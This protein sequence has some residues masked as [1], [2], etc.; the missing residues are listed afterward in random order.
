MDK[1]VAMEAAEVAMVKAAAD[2]ATMKT[3]D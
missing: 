1:A 2:A 3:A